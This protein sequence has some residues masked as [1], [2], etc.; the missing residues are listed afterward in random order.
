[1]RDSKLTERAKHMR[2]NMSEPETRLWLELRAKRFKGIAFRRQKVIGNYIADFASND[3]KIIVEVDGD[4]HVQQEDYDQERSRYLSSQGYAV[5]RFTNSDVMNNLSGMLM[6]L[7]EAISALKTETSPL[8]SP[9]RGSSLSPEGERTIKSP[10]PSGE[11]LR[12]G[13]TRK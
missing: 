10:S 3:P 5:I 6:Q 9:L 1:M 4:T 7:E 11:G 13:N 12:E 2:K 8:P